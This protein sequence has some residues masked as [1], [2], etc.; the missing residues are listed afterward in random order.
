MAEPEND[1]PGLAGR[2]EGERHL[3]P[4]R[5]Y[6]EDTDFTGLVY[7]AS[8]LRFCERGRS[9]FV[10]L[11]GISHQ[12]LLAGKEDGE[13]AV[14]VVRHM[15]IDFLKPARIDDVIEVVT[16]CA[17]IGGATL[18][19]KQEVVRGGQVLVC[20]SVKVVLISRSGKPLR[21]GP[22][23]RSAFERFVNQDH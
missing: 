10:R 18:T 15:E 4:V 14:F 21:V 5:I 17:E 19:L 12:D 23:I 8:F 1:W 3:L 6:F 9:D 20:A 16:E 2:I 22:L 7:H 11:L 13:P